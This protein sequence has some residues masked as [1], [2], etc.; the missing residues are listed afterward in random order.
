MGKRPSMSSE[1]IKTQIDN[2]RVTLDR[3]GGQGQAD[4]QGRISD[5]IGRLQ[6]K[7]K[8]HYDEEYQM[9]CRGEPA[10]GDDN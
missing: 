10:T 4:L 8:E 3:L 7:L 6:R 9:P 2:L 1:E 5:S